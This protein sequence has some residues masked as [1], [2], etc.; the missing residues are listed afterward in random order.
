MAVCQGVV[1]YE[2]GCERVCVC[3]GERERGCACVK[4]FSLLSSTYDFLLFSSSTTYWEI[5]F[6]ES[7]NG[8]VT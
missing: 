7:M 2:C 1:V 3:V 6:I 8:P 4:L 5:H